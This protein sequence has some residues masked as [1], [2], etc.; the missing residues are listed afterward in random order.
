MGV[1]SRTFQSAG[2]I[3]QHYIPGAYSRI[4]SVKGASG[5]ASANNTVIMGQ[6]TGGKPAT[7]LQFNSLADAVNTLD[8]GP[9]MEAVRLAFNPGDD[10]IPQRLFAMRVNS[11]LAGSLNLVDGSAADMVKIESRDYGLHVN[12]INVTMAAGT[13]EGKKLTIVYKTS[14]ETFDNVIRKSLTITHASATV[15]IT[16]N[17]TTHSMTLSEGPITIDLNTYKTI[18]DLAAYINQQAGYSATVE[19]GQ[20]KASSL[21]LDSVATQSAVSGYVCQSTMQ[22]IIDELNNNSAL[23][24]ASAVNAA[25]DRVIPENLATTYLTGGSEGS[26]TPTEWTSA[27]V[28]LEAE[29]IQIVAT[30]DSDSAV[31]ASIKTHC[32][33]MSAVTGRKERQFYVGGAWSDTAAVAEAAAKVLNSK[34]GLYAFNGF[35]QRDVDGVE[36]DYDASYSAC[37]LAGMK[38]AGAIN[39]PLTFNTLNVISLE[40]KVTDS[41]LEQL[42]AGGVCTISYDTKGLPHVVR[43]VTTYQI[44]DLKW[45][46]DSMVTE[47]LYASRDLRSYL[48]DMFVGKAST[49]ITGG[50]LK[51][52]VSARLALYE[53]LGIFIANDDGIAWWNV[54]ITLSGDT[55]YI[56]YDA[57]VTAPINFE[58]ITNHFHE[59]TSVI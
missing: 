23:V 50:V 56:D 3:S 11:A 57:Y 44:D 49:S 15:S 59:L 45:N 12:Q 5:L 55:V 47:M 7:L 1:G 21:Y 19:S 43:A 26:Y 10:L 33:S 51:G 34:Y 46:E 52:A 41:D 14:T 6:C 20:E 18:G 13:T 35:T 22:S 36:Q 30:P 24:K 2:Q 53:D 39:A 28:A 58:F 8:S 29:D 4:D 25:N 9:L 37:L 42:I 31:H 38:A 54:V 27:L 48:E 40:N 32:E 16:N 17:S